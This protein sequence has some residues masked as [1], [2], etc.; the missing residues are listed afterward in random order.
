MKTTMKKLTLGTALV[1]ALSATAPVRADDTVYVAH[2]SL[3]VQVR[4]DVARDFA[5]QNVELGEMIRQ[6]VRAAAATSTAT[7]DAREPEEL[8]VREGA[9]WM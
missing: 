8:K 7:A 6:D 1:A 2:Q 3:T 5:R 4:K 9:F